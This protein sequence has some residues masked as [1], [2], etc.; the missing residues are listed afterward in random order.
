MEL[1][2]PLRNAI[3]DALTGVPRG[4]L[5]QAADALSQ[6]YRAERLD[7]RLHLHDDMAAR[8]YLATRLPATYAAIRASLDATAEMRP[9]FAPRT[10]LDIG[11][12]PGTALWAALGCWPSLADAILIERSTAIRAWGEKLTAGAP[13]ERIV[14]Q[15]GDVTAGPTESAPRELVLLGYVLSELAPAARDPLIERLWAL[16][17]DMLVIVEP[18]TPTGWLRMLAARQRLMAAG[19]HLIAPCP[20]AGACPIV[21]PDWC[22]FARRVAR[23]RLHRETKNAQ[24]PWEDEPYIYLAASRKPGRAPTARVIAPPRTASGRVT[25]KLCAS[26]GTAAERL[27]TRRE[28]AAFKVARRLH[29]GD[30]L[31]ATAMQGEDALDDDVDA[32]R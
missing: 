12:G 7:G 10:A 32:D 1:P 15:S 3:D 20:H 5:A 31:A 27:V 24:V 8:A 13:L 4:A 26:D 29:W 9:D 18:G 19:A 25:L 28:G 14:W 17:T 2:P 30:S 21:P 16:T 23:S 6:R 11:A 22:H